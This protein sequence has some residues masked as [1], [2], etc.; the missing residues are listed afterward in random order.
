[1]HD[2]RVHLVV[3]GDGETRP[4]LERAA[5]AQR[6]GDR[7]H[8]VGHADHDALPAVLRSADAFLL[9]SDLDAFPLVLLEAL[10][11]GLPAITTDAPGV[12]AMLAGSDAAEVVPVR[13]V[14]AMAA[15]V[16]RLAALRRDE[17]R[18]RGAS[19]RQLVEERYALPAI[20]DRIEQVYASALAGAAPRG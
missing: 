16:R 18:R 19:A 10:A 5:S 12:R 6:L 4:G 7:V 3:V 14:D 11:C 9:P 13:D 1:M 15:A 20:V 17:L 2:P 8:F